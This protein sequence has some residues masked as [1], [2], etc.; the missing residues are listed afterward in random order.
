LSYTV[1]YYSKLKYNAKGQKTHPGHKHKGHSDSSSNYGERYQ[2]LVIKQ[3]ELGTVIHYSKYMLVNH[4]IHFLF[5]L[6]VML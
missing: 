4:Y 3:T 6:T 1:H 2:C 5:V